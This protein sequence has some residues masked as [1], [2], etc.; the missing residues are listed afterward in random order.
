MA[1]PSLSLERNASPS[2]R[3]LLRWGLVGLGTVM[4][5]GVP[6]A[7]MAQS[8]RNAKT[9]TFNGRCPF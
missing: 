5:T 9:L 3:T 4:L 1:F 2:R 7:L 6:K 8:S